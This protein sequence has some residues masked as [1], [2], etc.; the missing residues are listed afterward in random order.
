MTKLNEFNAHRLAWAL[1]RFTAAYVQQDARQIEGA[2][3]RLRAAQDQ[4]GVTCVIDDT[5]DL[6]TRTVLKQAA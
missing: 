3:A 4:T 5:I 1:S 2:A 6:W